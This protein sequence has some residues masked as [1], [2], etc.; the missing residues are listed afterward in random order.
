MAHLSDTFIALQ[1]T[2]SRAAYHHHLLSALKKRDLITDEAAQRYAHEAARTGLPLADV[3]LANSVVTQR[4]LLV[5]EASLLGV[6]LI[7]DEDSPQSGLEDLVSAKDAA[8][9]E[10]LPWKIDDGRLIIA[11]PTAEEFFTTLSRLPAFDL[12]VEMAL[13]SRARLTQMITERYAQ[14]LRHAAETAVDEI[15]SCR[16]FLALSTTKFTTVALLILSA[17]L[18][19]VFA[20]HLF[21]ASL[22]LWAVAV[23]LAGAAMKL[24]ALLPLQNKNQIAAQSRSDLPFMSVMVPLFREEDIA[25]KLLR[26]LARLN[27]PPH[28]LE[29]L[30]ILEEKDTQ[31]RSLIAQSALPAWFRV[32][33]VPNGP[34]TTKPR[35]MNFA[36]HFARGDIIGIYDAEDAPAPDQLLRVARRFQT[37]PQNVGCIQGILDYYNPKAS[38]IA[39]CFTIEYAVWFRMILPGLMRLNLPLPLGG[40]T[41]FIRRRVLDHIGAWDAHNVTEDADLGIRL[42]RYGYRTEM[43][44]SVTREEA[45]FRMLPWM[46]QR[47][48]W[49]KGYMVTYLVNMR[50]PVHLARQLG[51]RGFLGFQLLFFVAINQFLLAPWLLSFWGISFGLDHPATAIFS[52]NAIFGLTLLMIGA[53]LLNISVTLFAL[54]SCTHRGLFRSLPL[55]LFYMPMGSIAAMKALYELIFDPFYWDKTAH[56]ITT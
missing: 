30:L 34:I 26:R 50:R 23:M 38:W 36:L 32:I 2:S 39:R 3:L 22:S 46:R 51:L 54:K 53:E 4:S 52:A 12:P 43:L 44:P 29:I 56:G 16:D 48:R 19:I 13:V 6:Q 25:A 14:D 45:N 49:L 9:F 15:D 55:M 28:L 37:A 18:A 10:V 8:T 1:K 41:L 47:S 40:T 20:P 11:T 24:L 35:A 5:L 31:T 33:V 7:N 21:V 17:M 42:A 27:Y